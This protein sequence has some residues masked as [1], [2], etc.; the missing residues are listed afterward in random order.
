MSNVIRL[1]YD[2]KSLPRELQELKP[3]FLL[4][5]I[6]EVQEAY[7]GFAAENGLGPSTNRRVQVALD[8]VL[9]NIARVAVQAMAGIFGGLQSLH[10]D[11]YDEALGTPAAPAARIAVAREPGIR[12]GRQPRHRSG[13]AGIRPS[14]WCWDR[15][16]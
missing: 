8:E 2:G 5:A 6:P 9:N 13:A 16:S 1:T 14:P 4:E 3:R 11:S 10:T 7:L 12:S 15:W